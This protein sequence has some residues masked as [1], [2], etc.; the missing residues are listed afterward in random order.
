MSVRREIRRSPATGT[1]RERWLV[2][3]DFEHADGRRER[4]RKVAPVQTRHGAEEYERQL[5]AAM[6]DPRRSR[7]KAPPFGKFV[8]QR[9]WPTYPDAAG[10][11]ERTRREKEGHLRLYLL[12]ALDAT[13]L[14][15]ITSEVVESL[16]ATLAARGIGPKTRNNVRATLRRI[17]ASAVEW[18]VIDAL[19]HLPHAKVPARETDFLVHEE[20]TRLVAAARDAVERAMFLFALH[21]GARAGEQLAIEWRDVDFDEGN[22]LIRRSSSLG[23]TGPTKSGHERAVPMSAALAQA[24]AAIAHT[25]GPLVFS[26]GDGTALAIGHLHVRLWAACRRA[27][28]RRIRWHDLRHSFA[29]QLVLAGVPL[30]QVQAWLGHSTIAMTMRYAHLAPGQGHEMIRVLDAP[31]GAMTAPLGALRRNPQ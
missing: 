13:P 26:H 7:S 18:A 3:V 9:W 5:R 25:R 20:S 4:V 27:G 24:L 29:S 2:D 28:L 31:R 8:R 15:E 14:D 17:L 1:V 23:I 12:P 16:F 30:G 11:R 19:P 10:N 21:T 6:L 22:V